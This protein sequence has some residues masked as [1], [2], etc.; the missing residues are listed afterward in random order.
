MMIK[1]Y[2]C[3]VMLCAALVISGA[4]LANN[5][6]TSKIPDNNS[7]SVW[8]KISPNHWLVKKEPIKKYTPYRSDLIL[9]EF[10]S[11]DLLTEQTIRSHELIKTESFT[12]ISVWASWCTPCISNLK[13]LMQLKQQHK[14]INIIGINTHD[15]PNTAKKFLDRSGNPFNAIFSDPKGHIVNK[16]IINNK[17]VTHSAGGIPVTLLVDRHGSIHRS[18]SGA[19]SDEQINDLLQTI[20]SSNSTDLEKTHIRFRLR[21]CLDKFKHT[22]KYCSGYHPVTLFNRY[23]L[24]GD[25]TI[26][27][28]CQWYYT[29]SYEKCL[30][31]SK[32]YCQKIAGDPQQNCSKYCSHKK[33]PNNAC[34]TRCENIRSSCQ[35]SHKLYQEWL[36]F[37]KECFKSDLKIAGCEHLH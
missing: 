10:S 3:K 25:V 8:K 29:R 28:A 18:V 2:L 19:I 13:T 36:K 37:D 15:D 32:T 20:N 16:F 30:S 12:V 17:P 4:A 9:P 22:S 5:P 23:F 31:Q 7:D 27:R 11:K 1:K 34:V 6:L 24:R 14:N 26:P 21:D 35:F 33:E